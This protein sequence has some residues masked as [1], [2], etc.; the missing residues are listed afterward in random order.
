MTIISSG[1]TICR[2]CILKRIVNLS[3]YNNQ[4]KS[5]HLSDDLNEDIIEYSD[6]YELHDS[7][8]LF[9]CDTTNDDITV[10]LLLFTVNIPFYFSIRCFIKTHG[11]NNKVIIKIPDGMTLKGYGED[12]QIVLSAL[13]DD[14]EIEYLCDYEYAIKYQSNESTIY[15]EDQT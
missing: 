11:T 15:V 12:K 14:V 7:D 5:V 1:I 3:Y 9:K 2:N 4:V 8:F 6:V 13:D 10:N